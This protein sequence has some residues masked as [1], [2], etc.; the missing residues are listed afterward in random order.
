[1]RPALTRPR[2][3]PLPSLGQGER[4]RTEGR[5]HRRR[6]R[7]APRFMRDPYLAYSAGMV[8]IA[9]VVLIVS[10]E[11]VQL[12]ALS[13]LA[14]L[15]VGAQAMLSMVPARLRPLTPLGWSF[16]RLGLSLLFVAGLVELSGGAGGSMAALFLPV[17]VAAAALGSVQAVVIGAVASVIY[18]AP[19]LARIGTTGDVALRGIT[20]AGVS[21]MLALGTRRLVVTVERTSRQLRSAMISERRR[22]R[23]IA[24][25]EEVSRLL[26]AGGPTGEVLDR[27]LGVLVERFGYNHVSIY[28]S[29]DGQL[30]LGA[31]RGYAHPIATFDGSAGVVGRAMR[32][33]R[34]QFVA[35]VSRDPDYISVF[36]EVT[37][38][39]CAPLLVDGQLLGVLN[40]EAG[41]RLDRTDRDLVATLADRVATVVALGRDRQALAE[42][43]AVFRSLHEFTQSVSGT[44][45]RD[46]L[47]AAM[48]DAARRVI[49]ADVVALTVLERE[50]GRYRVRAITDVDPGLLGREVRP[51]ESLAGRAIRERTLVI[52]DEFSLDKFPVA[53]R[54]QAEPAML[55]GAG[56]PLVRDGVVV[57]ALSLVRRDTTDAFRPIER[58]AMELLAGHAALALANAFLHAEVEQLA[59]RDPLTGLYNRRYFDDAVERVIATWHRSEPGIRRDVSAIIFD[60]DHFGDFNKRH[61]HQVGDLVL[62]TFATILRDRFR[63][64]DLVARLGGEEFIVILD[65]ADRAG[66]ERIA[67]DVR[68][69]LA[70]RAIFNEDGERL[71][72]TVSA[73]CTQL[74]ES[75]ATRD[76]LLRTADVALF[77]AKRGGRDRVVAA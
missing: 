17:V 43:A 76:Q 13:V 5:P 6:R 77:M 8:P 15:F 25:M 4:L 54:D 51:G 71:S 14:L 19:E 21:V 47:A 72:V 1:M 61:G 59:I 35:D 22:S 38:E 36:D 10:R 12:A 27:A 65:G 45:D 73:G 50:T 55:L 7:R 42:R 34:L 75:S 18:L 37:S 29:A 11:P 53:Y 66:A 46:R 2:G 49:H 39:I 62:R 64:S 69:R 48:V 41:D 3:M 52:D 30:V 63:T 26:V 33:H 20:L 68:T 56:I 58:E 32:S 40:V 9:A 60:L 31:Q 44:L 28:L 67:D 57:G 74:E 23:Q 24:G 70:A 16:L